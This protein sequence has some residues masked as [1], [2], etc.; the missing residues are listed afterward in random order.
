MSL[1][2]VADQ[3]PLSNGVASGGGIQKFW[4]AHNFFIY[5][6]LSRLLAAVSDF[7]DR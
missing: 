3:S 1:R 7:K 2:A 6:I 4:G 5:L